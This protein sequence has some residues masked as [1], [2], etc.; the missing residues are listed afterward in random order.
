MA[1][2]IKPQS[3]DLT[4]ALRRIADSQI[5]TGLA[6]LADPD[7]SRA[8]RIHQSRK[9]CK[10]LRGLI[11]LVRPG[12]D[13]YGE[14]NKTFRDLARLL[15]EARDATAQ[16]E[17]INA[18]ATRFE[19]AM[20]DAVFASVR[21]ALQAR[22]DR[23]DDHDIADR[24]E[25][26]RKGLT[27]ARKRVSDWKVD[28][29]PET[30]IADGIAKTHGRAVAAMETA[31]DTGDAEDFH[32]WRKR[33]KYHWYHL[34]LLK[35]TWP[36]MFENWIGAADRLSDDLGDHH[37]LAVFRS[38]TLPL[39]EAGTETARQALDG[40]TFGRVTM[41]PATFAASGPLPIRRRRRRRSAGEPWPGSWPRWQGRR[42]RCRR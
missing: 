11:R 42:G 37:D 16:I 39:I 20:A 35:R 34:R 14:E 41:R 4:D 30:V 36:E 5:G 29:A 18:L 10:K 15:S 19:D 2:S 25:T 12:F 6:E 9:R 24:L 40:S 13:S 32:E 31:A 22:R 26:M 33:V 3:E 17:T 38:K 8:E 21:K 23:L 27:K 7:L 1:Y 28:G